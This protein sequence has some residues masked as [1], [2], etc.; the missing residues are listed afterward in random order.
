MLNDSAMAQLFDIYWQS[1]S[2]ALWRINQIESHFV[3]HSRVRTETWTERYLGAQAWLEQNGPYRV[4]LDGANIAY[5]GQNW[6][7][8]GF[9]WCQIGDALETVKE[10]MPDDKAL[11]VSLQPSLLG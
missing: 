7:E 11:V 5:F 6:D 3:W 8:G 10:E 1:I 4:I 2:S 9:K